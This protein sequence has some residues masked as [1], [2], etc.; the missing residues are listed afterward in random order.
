MWRI[1]ADRCPTCGAP[2]DLH[3]SRS[4]QLVGCRPAIA[5]VLRHLARPRVVARV[6]RRGDR[7]G[8]SAAVLADTE[9][10]SALL[11]LDVTT[12]EYVCLT[13]AEVEGDLRRATAREAEV[14]VMQATYALGPIRLIGRLYPR[15]RSA[16]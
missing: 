16:Q 11:V 12:D 7:A 13:R 15:Q 1:S 14:I 4:G 5:G 2:V 3:F 6:W 9:T 8:H 10:D